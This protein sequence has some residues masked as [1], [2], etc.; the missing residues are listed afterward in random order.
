MSGGG[1]K[2][3]LAAHFERY[4]LMEPRDFAKLVYQSEFAGEHLISCEGESLER[5]LAEWE[6]LAAD[7]KALFLEDIGGGLVRLHLTA[8]KARGFSPAKVNEAFVRTASSKRGSRQGLERRFAELREAAEDGLLPLDIS[9]LETYLA[10]Y[11]AEGCPAV[12]H[13]EQYRQA[14]RPHYRVLDRRYLEL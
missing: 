7:G 5:L 11:R 3:I 4:P 8:A 10:A 1:F 13:S 12:R 6:G 9:K 2:S 14:Y